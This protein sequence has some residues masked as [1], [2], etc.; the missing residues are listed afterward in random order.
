MSVFTHKSVPKMSEFQAASLQLAITSKP[1]VTAFFSWENKKKVLTAFFFGK[2]KKK[3][4]VTT[5]FFGKLR[6]CNNCVFPLG[7]RKKCVVSAFLKFEN[8]ISDNFWRKWF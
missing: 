3:Y 8:H 6:K 4:V 1:K 5:F 7:N 2:L